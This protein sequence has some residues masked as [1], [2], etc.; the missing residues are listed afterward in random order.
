MSPFGILRPL[1]ILPGTS[2][3]PLSS[4]KIFKTP[5]GLPPIPSL[6]TERLIRQVLCHE[7]WHEPLLADDPRLDYRPGGALVRDRVDGL[8]ARLVTASG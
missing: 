7:T 5:H 3:T 2:L 6:E 1:H 8:V 4:S